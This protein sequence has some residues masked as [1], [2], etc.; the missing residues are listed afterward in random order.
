VHPQPARV[1]VDRDNDSWRVEIAARDRVGLLA[2]A[3]P[4]LLD[5]E[6]SIQHATA[7]TW[8]NGT[9]LASFR[10]EVDVATLQPEE[11]APAESYE[12][13]SAGRD[14]APFCSLPQSRL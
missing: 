4:V 12:S 11:F 9:A 14:A 8:G 10:R 7:T 13:G 2:R 5:A 3:T 1:A 6:C